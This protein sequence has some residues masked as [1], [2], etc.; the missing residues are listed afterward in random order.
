MTDLRERTLE[1]L[2]RVV[3]CVDEKVAYAAA[4]P[5]NLSV[6]GNINGE[7]LD[8]D[9]DDDDDD[10]VDCN[11]WYRRSCRCEWSLSLIFVDEVN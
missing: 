10:S 5:P 1:E 3:V 11:L 6:D 7:D 4:A 8:D 2:I 9:D